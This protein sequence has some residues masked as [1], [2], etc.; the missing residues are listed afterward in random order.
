MPQVRTLATAHVTRNARGGRTV[1][2]TL[3][4][5]VV[6]DQISIVVHFVTGGVAILHARAAR[7]GA[8]QRKASSDRCFLR[9]RSSTYQ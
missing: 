4:R 1:D 9:A 2:I 6:L 8:L 7:G 5:V 3:I